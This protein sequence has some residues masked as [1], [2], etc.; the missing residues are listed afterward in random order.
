M[1]MRHL[2]FSTLATGCLGAKD[3]PIEPYVE[4]PIEYSAQ[5][6]LS[7]DFVLLSEDGIADVKKDRHATTYTR[8]V[9][10]WMPS[11][12]GTYLVPLEATYYDFENDG[13]GPG[14]WFLGR[15]EYLTDNGFNDINFSV[16]FNEQG[17]DSALYITRSQQYEKSGELEGYCVGYSSNEERCQAL[18]ENLVEVVVDATNVMSDLIRREYLF[19][20]E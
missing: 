6:R 5:E 16:R 7:T 11:I 8:R 13:L 10:D 14:D 18:E 3:V 12:E 4:T 17:F 1:K 20:E 9:F 2:R 19:A 15:F